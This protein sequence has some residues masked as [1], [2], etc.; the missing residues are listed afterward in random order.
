MY[1]KEVLIRLVPREGQNKA[2]QSSLLIPILSEQTSNKM[3]VRRVDFV[4]PQVGE[5]L[6]EDGGL[7]VLYAVIAILM[8]L[9]VALMTF[10]WAFI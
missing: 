6:R 8:T 7:A 1:R 9:A 10:V 5:E 4:G 3:D 2:E